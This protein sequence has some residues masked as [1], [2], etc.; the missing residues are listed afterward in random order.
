M[1]RGSY[2]ASD[3][4][5]LKSSFGSETRAEKIYTPRHSRDITAALAGVTR[6]ARDNADSPLS[7]PVIIGFDVTASMGYLAS[8]LA[9]NALNKA[10]MYLYKNKPI[11]DP[12]VMCCAI[13]DCKSDKYPLQVTQFES[14]IRIIKQLTC[15]DLEGGG[16]GNGGESY[17]L[18]WYFAAK[19]TQTDC[20]EKRHKKGYLITIG[21]DNCHK[22]LTPAE[23]KRVFGDSVSYGLSNEELIT[24]ADEKYNLFHICI[25]T[26][27]TGDDKIYANWRRLLDGRTAEIN[28][29]DMAYLPE[30][31]FTLISMGEGMSAND[32]LS[33]IDQSAAEKTANSL[34]FIDLHKNETISF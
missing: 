33:A 32:A 25:D 18:A 8:E 29:K 11:N 34:A 3:W 20:Y 7:T 24:M 22:L 1:G 6:Q 30:L 19:R 21:D 27:G 17:N 31:I 14:D 15:L 28:K 12:Q 5:K 10:I 9:L 26:G 16:G 2:T 23:I 4:I 13:G